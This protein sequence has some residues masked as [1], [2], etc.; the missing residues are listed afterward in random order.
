MAMDQGVKDMK[1]FFFGLDGPVIQFL[2]KAADCIFVSLLCA[3]FSLPVV[4]IGASLAAANKVMCDIIHETDNGIIKGF[5]TAFFRNFMKATIA[6]LVFVLLVALLLL[7]V[8]YVSANFTGVI[9][10]ALYLVL[11]YGTVAVLGCFS[12]ILPLVIRYENSM[13]QHGKNAMI[14]TFGKLPRTFAMILLNLSPLIIYLLSPDAFF[15]TVILW[16]TV[17]VGAVVYMN[18]CMM[19]PIYEE[20]EESDQDQ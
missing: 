16:P 3:L 2:C 1:N 19:K 7:C 6:W 5:V 15:K 13:I 17:G 12:Y 14:L 18:Q 9:A 4:T 10:L 20:L 8:M 11:L